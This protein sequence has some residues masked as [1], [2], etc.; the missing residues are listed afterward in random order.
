MDGLPPG[1][2]I[3]HHH[4]EG[5]ALPG[6]AIF[7]HRGKKT[8][9]LLGMMAVIREFLKETDSFLG[10]FLVQLL[11]SLLNVLNNLSKL[12]LFLQ[13]YPILHY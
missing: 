13:F 6:D 9:L 8:V 3:H 2:M 1:D 7:F 10:R 12:S 4:P 11:L 5:A